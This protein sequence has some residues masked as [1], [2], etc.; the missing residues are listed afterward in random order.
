[1]SSE[2][3]V[4]ADA[5]QAR[6]RRRERDDEPIIAASTWRLGVSLDKPSEIGRDRPAMARPIG[7]P[8]VRASSRGSTRVASL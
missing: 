6:L 3:I 7:T 1:V 8:A 4:V 5:S 2:W